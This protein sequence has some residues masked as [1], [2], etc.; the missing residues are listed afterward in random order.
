M[1]SLH[2]EV[3][4]FLL[5]L[6]VEVIGTY[7]VQGIQWDDYWPAKPFNAGHDPLSL[8]EYRTAKGIDPPAHD[9]DEAWVSYRSERA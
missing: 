1:N 6:V 5:D 4:Q 7:E 9:R 8:A 2:P 3:Q